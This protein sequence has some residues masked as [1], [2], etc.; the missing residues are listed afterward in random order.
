VKLWDHQAREIQQHAY[1]PGWFQLWD[2]RTGKTLPAVHKIAAWI[3][4]GARHILVVA[5]KSACDVW[6]QDNELGRFDPNKVAVLDLSDGPIA[7]RKRRLAVPESRPTVAVVN[8]SALYPM[9]MVAHKPGPLRTWAPDALILDES[10]EFKTASAQCSRAALM[11]TAGTQYRLALTG[12]PDPEDYVDFYGQLK[13]ICPEVLPVR[14]DE[15]G[16]PHRDL[17]A[18]EERYVRKN[19]IYP[20]KIDGYF[21]LDELR[22]IIFS[23]AS[24]VRQSDCFDMPAVRDI[25]ISVPLPRIARELYTELVQNTV[26]D[27]FGVEIDATHQLSRLTILHQLAAGFIRNEGEVEWV[28]DEKINAALEEINELNRAGK[29][30]VLFHRYRVEGER[31]EAACCKRFGRNATRTLHGD[32]PGSARSA[33]PFLQWPDLRIYI[34]QEDTANMSI[35]LREADH[36]IWTSW[37]TKANVH[38]QAR[39]RI[40][41]DAKDKPHGLTYTYLEVPNTVDRFNRELIAKKRSASELLLDIGFENAAYG[42]F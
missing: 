25:S 38:Y 20:S 40:F 23:R 41:D 39:Q 30:V 32:T 34:A 13:I 9:T 5:P 1:E 26:A 22:S 37:G 2:P 19:P 12:T 8:R 21:N 42:R 18:F 36:V 3:A 33:T 28:H 14:I 11:L 10:H 4:S 31:L 15:K 6:L 35:S 24:R 27:F 16:K 17:R 7:E 29:R